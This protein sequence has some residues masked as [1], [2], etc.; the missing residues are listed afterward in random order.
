MDLSK[1]KKGKKERRKKKEEEKKRRV[2][3][4]QKSQREW[5]EMML[6]N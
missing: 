4:A 5:K 2:G 6:K 3:I 1:G